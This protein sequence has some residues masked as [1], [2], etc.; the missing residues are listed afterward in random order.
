LSI[1][2]TE[3]SKKINEVFKFDTPKRYLNFFFLWVKKK[4][5]SEIR[6]MATMKPEML[7]V[8]FGFKNSKF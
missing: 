2:L 4:F 1:F 8:V 5:I 3:N 7:L 6:L